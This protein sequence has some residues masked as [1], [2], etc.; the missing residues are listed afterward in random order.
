VANKTTGKKGQHQMAAYNAMA[1]FF[2]RQ[3]FIG[4]ASYK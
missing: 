3:N 1:R 4:A 2:W